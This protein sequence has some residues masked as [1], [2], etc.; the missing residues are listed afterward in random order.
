[1]ELLPPT[2][3]QPSNKYYE[4]S[5]PTDT[6]SYSN[7]STMSPA[8]LIDM[9]NNLQQHAAELQAQENKMM[10]QFQE[11]MRLWKTAN[12]IQNTATTNKKALNT[13][14]ARISTTTT[15]ARLNHA[16]TVGLMG[17]ANN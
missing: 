12:I 1:M 9:A 13:S 3:S 14:K 2:T 11:V 5:P 15:K 6:L 7:A 17:H 10:T 4:L 16:N 8:A